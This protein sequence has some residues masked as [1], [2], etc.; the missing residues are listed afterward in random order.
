MKFVASLSRQSSRSE[1]K[2]R[3]REREEESEDSTLIY[4]N[5]D[6]PACS[7]KFRTPL[8]KLQGIDANQTIARTLPI[9][10]GALLNVPD[11]SS[12]S[13]FGTAR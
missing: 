2:E 7:R 9:A 1:E 11:S 12:N 8:V 3:E 13:G 10:I 5:I 4:Q 6:A